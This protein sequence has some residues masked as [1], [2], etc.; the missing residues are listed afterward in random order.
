MARLAAC[1]LAISVAACGGEAKPKT[2]SPPVGIPAGDAGAGTATGIGPFSDHPDHIQRTAIRGAPHSSAIDLVVLAADGNSALSR[3]DLGGVRLWTVLDGSAEPM[4]IPVRGAQS[5]AVARATDHWIAAIVDAAGAAHIMRATATGEI[6]ELAVTPPHEQIEQIEVLPDAKHVVVLRADHTIALLGIDGSELA[7]LERRDYRP[8]Q[9]RVTADGK[10]LTAL[11]VEQAKDKTSVSLQRIEITTG[12]KPA[13]TV[14]GKSPGFTAAAAMGHPHTAV[15]PSGDEFAYLSLDAANAQIWKL[16]VVDLATGTER[17]L[18]AELQLANNAA[19]GY[20][21]EDKLVVSS[22]PFG[23]TWLADL[24]AGGKFFPRAGPPT[25]FAN[26]IMPEAFATRTRVIGIGRWLYV[27]DIIKGES[28]YLG[29]SSF[30]PISVSFAPSGNAVVWVASRGHVFVEPL[31]DPSSPV[32]HF[33]TP[34]LTP[35]FRAFFIDDDHLIFADSV[36]GLQLVERMTNDE[37]S[38]ADASGPFATVSYD[39][40]LALLR[41]T[42]SMGETWVYDVDLAK[43]FAGPYIVSDRSNTSGLLAPSEGSDAVL[44]TLDPGLTYRR[45]TLAELRKGLSHDEMLERGAP[46]ATK[47]GSSPAAIGRDGARYHLAFDDPAKT[48][49]HIYVGDALER[50]IALATNQVGRVIPS[51]DG[52]MLAVIENGGAIYVYRRATGALAWSVSMSTTINDL[53]WS[54]D[55]AS[56]AAVSLLGA[57][58][59]DAKSGAAIYKTCGPRFESRVTAPANLFPSIQQPNI[60]E[61]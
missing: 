56:L 60:C 30:E 18:D 27:Q 19:I 23:Q 44:W 2:P 1:A 33:E 36:G 50:T 26:A 52:A 12:A 5:F 39:A 11:F 59:Y 21:G 16:T 10:A 43:G 49:L 57:A 48:S 3:D 35:V 17:T 24:G 55:S 47:S 29:Y 22:I 45:Y 14:T 6:T 28:R 15:S 42:R 41:L 54:A 37:L 40:E 20:V 25:H 31:D 32:A 7:L 8:K 34:V 4:V 46:L 53:A 13:L 9:L 61:R 58:I 51:E 38:A